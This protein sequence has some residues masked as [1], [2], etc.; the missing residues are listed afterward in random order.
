[1]S[2]SVRC[3]ALALEMDP[4]KIVAAQHLDGLT[5]TTHIE[6]R[7]LEVTEANLTELVTLANGPVL[8]TAL[9]ACGGLAVDC[10]RVLK[11]CPDTAMVIV[12]CC[13]HWLRKQGLFAHSN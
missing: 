12:G 6:Y 11:T 5:N 10:L 3:P 13:Y 8:L 2:R 1:M 4:L 9:H 7:L